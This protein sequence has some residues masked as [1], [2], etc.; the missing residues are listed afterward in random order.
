M[1]FT[2]DALTYPVRGDGKYILLIGAVLSLLADVASFAPLIGI[3][4]QL[5][6]FGYFCTV[7]FEIIQTSST[8]SDEAP[9]FP[10]VSDP[11]EDIVKPAFTVLAVILLSALPMIAYALFGDRPEGGEIPPLVEYGSM[12]FF[13]LYFPIAMLAAVN[14]GT[15]LAALPHVVIISI[16]RAGPLY[17]VA[18]A[19]LLAVYIAYNFLADRLLTLPM[20]AWPLIWL[21]GMYTMMV[22]GRTLGLLYRRREEE[23]GWI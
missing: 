7:Y 17:F 3:L 15:L 14:C 9:Q 22:N 6:L 8:G 13:V 18:V 5:I 23:L 2:Q 12:A 21:F 4:A 11:M 20:F 1:S 10:G 16:F 19:I